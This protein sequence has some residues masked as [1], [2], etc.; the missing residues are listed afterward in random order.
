MLTKKTCFLALIVFVSVSA[1]GQNK[2]FKNGYVITFAQDTIF[3]KI[4]KQNS[5]NVICKFQNSANEII[6]YQPNEIYAFGYKNGNV[7]VSK[8]IGTDMFFVEYLV[9]GNLNLYSFGNKKNKRYFVDNELDG[10]AEIRLVYETIKGES[11]MKLHKLS[12]QHAE[13][14]CKFTEK[15]PTLKHKIS[16]INHLEDENL[17]E[18]VEKHNKVVCGQKKCNNECC[19]VFQKNIYKFNFELNPVLG[20]NAF[21][22]KDLTFTAGLLGYFKLPK[23]DNKLFVKAGFLYSKV[24]KIQEI[25]KQKGF[26]QIPIQIEARYPFKYFRPKVAIGINFTSLKHSDTFYT[27]MFS[28]GTD[29]S[30][31]KKI[32]F[33]LNYDI[34]FDPLFLIIPLK[35]SSHSLLFGVNFVF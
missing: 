27:T 11:G 23:C 10:L 24:T 14:L 28:A 15:V 12:N 6:D 25:T 17:I 29:I 31:T 2:K 18:I 16:K 7:Y 8:K 21:A 22:T 34:N 1:F 32:F 19:K 4:Y 9:K 13:L 30:L 33:S 5:S 20:F 35:V 3:G 26:V